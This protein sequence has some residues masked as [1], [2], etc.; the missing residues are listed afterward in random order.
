MS[1]LNIHHIVSQFDPETGTIGD[2]PVI[3]RY[4]S[5]LKGSFHHQ[6]H[7]DEALSE[8]DRLVYTVA[9]VEPAMGEG[10]L[11]YGLGVIFPGKIGDEYHLTKG[12]LHAWRPAA[13][14]Y[15]GL[16]GSGMMLLEDEHTGESRMVPLTPNGVVYVPGNTAHRTMNVGDE[17][18]V[19]LGVYPARAGH[20]YGSIATKNFRYVV[21]E[22]D[23][24]PAMIERS[25][26]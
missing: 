10:D 20:D 16:K 23:G 25:T 18:L 4:L 24:V 8:G 11:H 12:H 17:P 15:I 7:F 21:V 6:T 9:A 3:R 26:L 1:Q 13:E 19:Y 2:A 5:D 14:F 22:R